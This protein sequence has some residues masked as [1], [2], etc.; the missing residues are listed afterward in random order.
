M[1]GKSNP[2]PGPHLNGFPMPHYSYFFPHMLGGISPPAMPGLPP[3]GYSTPSP[4]NGGVSK[5]Y[6]LAQQR[7]CWLVWKFWIRWHGCTLKR[8]TL[9]RAV[10]VF[11]N[12]LDLAAIDALVLFKQCNNNT[13]PRR[14]FIMSLAYGLRERHMRAKATAKIP[15]EALRE[16]NCTQ[17]PVRRLCQVARCTKN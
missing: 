14:D 5:P 7:A 9:R 6:L 15:R 10:A 2:V 3:S 4:A 1:A 13:M 8:G 11:Y 17:L 16:P 12:T